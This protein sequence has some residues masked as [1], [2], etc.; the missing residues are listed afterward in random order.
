MTAARD[1][2]KLAG[3]LVTANQLDATIGR[4]L[5]VGDFGIGGDAIPLASNV[6]WDTITTPGR[7]YIPLA[8]GTNVPIS[9]SNLFVDVTKNGSI[10]KQMAVQQ[11][12]ALRVDRAFVG[13]SWLTWDRAYNQTSI[14]GGVSQL[15]GQPTGAIIEQGSNANGTYIKYADGTMVCHRTSTSPSVTSLSLAAPLF[16]TSSLGFTFPSAFVGSVPSVTPFAASPGAAIVWGA[17]EGSVSLT[18]YQMRITSTSS[19]TSAFAGY[20]AIG[21]WF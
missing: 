10:I 6:S 19:T 4:L 8:T 9:G 12:S 2:A 5:Q 1:L 13:G 16:V 20:I 11:G 21:R 3:K 17:T 14:L 7:Y 18:T 15:N